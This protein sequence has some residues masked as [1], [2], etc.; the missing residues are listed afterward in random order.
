MQNTA[1]FLYLSS[2]LWSALKA[3]LWLISNDLPSY[4]FLQNLIAA[5][6]DFLDSGVS[7]SATD[8]VLLHVAPASVELYTPVSHL[9]L[10]VRRPVQM[11]LT[12]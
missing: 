11:I 3:I 5:S 6:I 1:A 4:Q 10:E 12:S 8:T 9:V 7:V 2:S